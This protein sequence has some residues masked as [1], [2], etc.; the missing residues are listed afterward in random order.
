MRQS[1][2]HRRTQGKFQEFKLPTEDK[3]FSEQKLEPNIV[4]L[5]SYIVYVYVLCISLVII[6]SPSIG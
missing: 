1:S 6:Y 2:S 5:Y 4:L 3:N